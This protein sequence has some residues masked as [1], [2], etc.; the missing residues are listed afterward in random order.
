MASP[1]ITGPPPTR[2]LSPSLTAEVIARIRRRKQLE[3]LTC[4][5]CGRPPASEQIEHV[6]IGTLRQLPSCETCGGWWWVDTWPI[7]GAWS[8]WVESD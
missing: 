7:A 3:Q 2:P 4:A 1:S 8:R 6:V 5:W